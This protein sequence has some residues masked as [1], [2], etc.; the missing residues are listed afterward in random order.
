[1]KFNADMLNQENNILNKPHLIKYV[2]KLMW[3]GYFKEK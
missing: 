2:E 3:K 1:M